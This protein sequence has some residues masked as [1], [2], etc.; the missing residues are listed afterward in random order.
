MFVSLQGVL[1]KSIRRYDLSGKIDALNTCD[2]SVEIILGVIKS[3]VKVLQYKNQ[4]ILLKAANGT[5]ANEIK[6]KELIIK[7]ELQKNNIKV[8]IIKC[9]I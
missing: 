1:N 6:L 5:V 7:K 8:N 9:V 2:A 4:I 3:K